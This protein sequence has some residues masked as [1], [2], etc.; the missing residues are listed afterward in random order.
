MNKLIALEIEHHFAQMS[1]FFLAAFWAHLPVFMCIAWF[2]DSSIWQALIIGAI[3]LMG[4]TLLYLTA[5]GS[6][7]T[8][9]SL[10]IASECL[11]ALLIHLGKGQ[12]EMH[13]YVFAMISFLSVFAD[14][15]IIIVAA[16]T[17]ILHHFAF[18]FFLP[19]SVFN[20]Q[21]SIWTVVEHAI[22]VIVASVPACII[23]KVFYNYMIGGSL[24]LRRLSET[25]RRLGEASEVLTRSAE[26]LANDASVQANSIEATSSSMEEL[27]G[28]VRESRQCT[29]I[30]KERMSTSRK[31]AE[32]CEDSMK[33]MVAILE[34]IR[35]SGQEM[36]H[37]MDG[38]KESSNAIPKVIKTIDEIAFQTNILALNAAV[39]A[40]RAGEAG[41][42]F[43]VVADEVRNLA[44]RSASAAHETNML[45]ET[46]INRG[47]EG[48]QINGKVNGKLEAM[49]GTSQYFHDQLN[50]ILSNFREMDRLVSSV[51]VT[52]HKQ[53]KGIEF[54]NQAIKEIKRL[55]ES[56]SA[57]AND[58]ANEAMK[59]SHENM[60]LREAVCLLAEMIG[61]KEC[62]DIFDT[63][64]YG[65][66]RAPRS[67]FDQDDG[68]SNK[69]FGHRNGVTNGAA[70]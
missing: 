26:S 56:H 19:A 29:E 27:S 36:T 65:K 20:Y 68:S 21:A 53:G 16:I 3:I 46:S 39:E 48:V 59:I 28:M 7:L 47:E 2:W 44:K 6:F 11:S 49:A 17:L 23:A 50:E 61:H 69:V 18:F 35:V 5:P 67:K 41:L 1:R 70:V 31:T 38:I 24:A 57:K 9:L 34:D 12:I 14:S 22:F 51:T 33:K 25:V 63:A 55:T 4:P 40:A 13:F 10:G 30:A 54:V 58:Q 62:A 66:G 42:G 43:A 32:A 64:S 52:E 15:R 8:A 45:I 60:E 37:A